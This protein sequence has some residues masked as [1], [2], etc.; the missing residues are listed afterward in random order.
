M[1]WL[2]TGAR[3]QLGTHL[4]AQL[5]GTNAG[6][7]VV[8]LGRSEL[9]ITDA[10][11]VH[12]AFRAASP[13]VVINAAAYT[14][15]DAAETDEQAAVLLNATAV[16]YL[17][18]AV[19]AVGARL[20]QVSTDYVFSGRAERPYQP[21]DPTDPRTAYGRSK[22]AGESAAR[23]HGGHVVRTAWVYGGPGANFVDTMLRLAT[24][25]PTV[26]V[27]SDQIGSP[28][29]VADLAAGLIELGR[30]RLDSSVLPDSSVLHYANAGQASW[31]ELARA[32]FAG[33]G[34][35]PDRVHPVDSA[36]FVRPAPRPLWSV[37]SA[38]SWTRSGLTPPP[39]WADG[40]RRCLAA[41]DRLRPS[42]RTADRH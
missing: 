16:E 35:D 41:G 24:E 19:E 8:A 36:Q 13:G 7:E 3:G 4:V 29:Y 18:R 25:R 32:V 38:D 1:R 39:T 10:G 12:A 20:I 5:A 2:I 17:G 15:V 6:D 11:A 33:A 37:L 14:A 28:T 40:L 27:V 34:H 42:E 21:D 30:A 22:L 31:Y 9:D 23:A 26:D